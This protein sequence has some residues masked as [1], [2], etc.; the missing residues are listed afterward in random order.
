MA[1]F[2]AAPYVA[3]AIRSVLAQDWTDF[4]F[5]IV[6]DAST[7]GTRE[8][9][10]DLAAADRR[11]RLLRHESNKGLSVARNLGIAEAKGEWV[12]FLDADDLYSPDMLRLA[13][14]AGRARGAGMVLWDYAVFTDEAE[15]ERNRA[16]ASTLDRLDPADRHALLGRP[17]FA[18]TRLVRRDE[19]ARLAIAFPPGLTYQDVPVHWHLVTQIERI[20]LL[21]RRLAFYRQQPH[22][23]TAGK[24]MKRAD[25]FTVLDQVE[26]YLREAG[27]FDLYEDI[28]TARQLEAWHGIHD[29]VAAEHKPRVH[30]MIVER[31]TERHRA[32][33]GSG[34][35]LRW[36]SRA[37]FR[38]LDGDRVA[39]LSLRLREAA[40]HLYRG[41]KSQG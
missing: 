2:N 3:A 25:Y 19:L 33:A 11:I 9:L 22:A 16:R 5:I 31:L 10:R 1:A 15:I 17:A 8:I 30:A 28:L 29:V 13:L 39:A 20:A 37:F 38:G 35:P 12:A 18:W 14:A 32:Y 34:K 27:L 26:A 7:D 21:P 24:G 6:D 41:M 36:Q 4:E 23:T 40:R